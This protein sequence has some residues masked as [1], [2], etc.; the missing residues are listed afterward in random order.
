MDLQD[1]VDEN[2]YLRKEVSCSKTR[3][4]TDLTEIDLQTM[5]FFSQFLTNFGF[6]KLKITWVARF[7]DLFTI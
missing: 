2:G 5:R 6:S 1:N 7:Q 4:I 3:E